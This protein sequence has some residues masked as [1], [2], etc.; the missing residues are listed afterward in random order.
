[1]TIVLFKVDD[2]LVGFSSMVLV[3]SLTMVRLN[4]LARSFMILNRFGWLA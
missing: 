4:G 3:H 2:S 1:M